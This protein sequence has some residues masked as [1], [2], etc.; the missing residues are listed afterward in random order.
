M[1]LKRRSPQKLMNSQ[2]IVS[3]GWTV[4]DYKEYM[5]RDITLIMNGKL[6]IKPFKNIKELRE[7]LINYQP[8]YKMEIE[9]LTKY[10]S[11]RYKL[12][13]K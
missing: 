10:F 3:N 8:F 2:R 12:K 7:Y 5:R 1:G 4:L 11:K 13:E 6:W 9:E